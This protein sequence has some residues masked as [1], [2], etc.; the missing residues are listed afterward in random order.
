[1]PTA[2]AVEDFLATQGCLDRAAGDHG[3]FGRG[4]LV[5]EQLQLAAET[6]ANRGRDDAHL[7][8]TQ[9]ERLCQLFVDVVWRL[10]AGPQR[11]LAGLLEVPVGDTCM[12]LQRE[13]RI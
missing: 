8:F 12:L 4:R 13:M 10:G 1:M 9:P 6:A 11:Q 7:L 3:Q 5:L 2:M